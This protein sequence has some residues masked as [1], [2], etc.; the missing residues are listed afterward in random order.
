MPSMLSYICLYHTF[1]PIFRGICFNYITTVQSN[2]FP[3][4]SPDTT[5][6][7]FVKLIIFRFVGTV[8]RGVYSTLVVLALVNSFGGILD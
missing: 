4:R 2:L 8:S 5:R 7:N 6:N 3:Y 1:L